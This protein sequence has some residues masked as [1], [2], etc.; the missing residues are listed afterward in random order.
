MAGV[1]QLQLEAPLLE[2]IPRPASSTTQSLPSPPRSHP[3]RANQ[4]AIASSSP[5]NDENVRVCLRGRCRCG[6]VCARR[7]PPR[8]C[9]CPPRR[10]APPPDPSPTPPRYRLG[11]MGRQGQPINDA[12]RRAQ[13]N[14]S[15]CREDPWRQSLRRARPH[16]GR[17]SSAGPAHHSHPSWRPKAMR[18]QAEVPGVEPAPRPSPAALGARMTGP[19]PRRGG[20]RQQGLLA[21]HAGAR[22]VGVRRID[23]GLDHLGVLPL[24]LPLLASG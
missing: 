24:P 7:R 16:Q 21:V 17:A 1:D 12:V 15:W 2:H 19:R 4:S 5:V 22:R 23:A 14:S 13:D 6:R 20:G 11:G 3:R 8:P 9:R 10:S 18:S